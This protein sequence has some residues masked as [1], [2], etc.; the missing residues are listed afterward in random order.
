MSTTID[1]QTPWGRLTS[2]TASSR[3]GFP[4][5]HCRGRDYGPRDLLPLNPQVAEVL[6]KAGQPRTHGTATAGDCI[7]QWAK[8]EG[9]T[10]DEMAAAE[11]FLSQLG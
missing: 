7:R 4:V 10:A 9:R 5:L 2:R 3:Y 6:R 11:L 1:M 8:E